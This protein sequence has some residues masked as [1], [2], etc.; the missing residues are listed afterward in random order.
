MI[1]MQE[2]SKETAAKHPSC[3][4]SFA[5]RLIFFFYIENHPKDEMICKSLY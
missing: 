3:S 2:L 1:H 5:F 4:C